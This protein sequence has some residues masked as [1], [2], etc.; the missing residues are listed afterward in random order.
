MM[1]TSTGKGVDFTIIKLQPFRRL[2]IKGQVI[3][4]G[5]GYQF[6]SFC[7]VKIHL[8]HHFR[9][10]CTTRLNPCLSNTARKDK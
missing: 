9:N 10:C 1:K 5:Y 8:F 7:S 3:G 2:L 4:K 6:T